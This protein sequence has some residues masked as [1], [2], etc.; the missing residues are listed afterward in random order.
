M[1]VGTKLAATAVAVAAV[2]ADRT[3]AQPVSNLDLVSGPTA[4]DVARFYP[5]LAERMGTDGVAVVQCVA[6]ADGSL[7]GCWP[8][9]EH[10]QGMGFGAAALKLASLIKFR[11]MARDGRV[12]GGASVSIPIRF[13]IPTPLGASSLIQLEAAAG[14][15]NAK[16]QYEL[17]RRYE[18]GQG[19]AQNPA[20]AVGW[21][22]K[23]GEQGNVQAQYALGVIFSEGLGVARDYAQAFAWLSK[24]AEQGYPSAMLDLSEIYYN[25]LGRPADKVQAVAWLRKAADTGLSMAQLILGVVSMQGADGPAEKAAAVAWVRKAADQG[26]PQGMIALG[27]A[28]TAG[29]GVPQ[30]YAQAMV[31]FRKAADQGVGFASII[32]GKRYETGYGVPKDYATALTCYG[33]AVDQGATEALYQLGKFYL[34]GHGGPGGKVKA[35]MWFDLFLSSPTF[36]DTQ[37]HYDA[38]TNRPLAIAART[39]LSAALTAAQRAEAK[40]LEADWIAKHRVAVR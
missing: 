37:D 35:L 34:D 6:A 27:S 26:D 8:I 18:G 29:Q 22:A 9:S 19:V 24:A 2:V 4:A 7:T 31:W 28:Y 40:S 14:Q 32:I 3:E 20:Q 12:I 23:A 25:G 38:L 36:A 39:R 30:D 15:G 5:D 17:G 10:P 16:A 21:Y 13:I 11:P 1:G 33:K